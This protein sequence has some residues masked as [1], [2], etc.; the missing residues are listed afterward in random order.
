[1][2]NFW[3]QVYST[4]KGLFYWLNWT[5]YLTNM[6]IAPAIFVISYSILGRFALG[7][8]AAQFY[9]LGITMS[10][11]T[12]ILISGITQAYTYDRELGTISFFYVS[13]ANRLVNFLSRPVL[14]Y[15]NALLV[16]A[17][18]FTTLCL[19]VDIDL[20]FMNWT[21]FSLALLVTAASV[22]AFAQFLSVFTI[23]IRDWIN[24]MSLTTGILLVF[25]GMMIPVEIFPPAIQE[26][27]KLLPVTNGL[28]AIRAA[29][30][31][32]VF[33]DVSLVIL[34]EALTGLV[35]LT[36]GFIGFTLFER[37]AKRTGALE[38]EAFG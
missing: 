25:T 24:I 28:S 1:M 17:T 6:F 21:S 13:P 32:A 23:I 5:S 3:V 4:Y 16:F 15:P 35:Y 18:G 38:K 33:S 37:V 8:E 31:G 29:F 26:L 2:Y 12:F 30:T 11:T 14:H 9:G 10:H 34:R 19:L 36:I 27:A 20:S 22:A 7:P